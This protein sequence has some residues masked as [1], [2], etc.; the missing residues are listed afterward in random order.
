[1]G[2]LGEELLIVGITVRGNLLPEKCNRYTSVICEKIGMTLAHK[3]SLYQYPL[4]G[5]GGNGFTFF[6]PITESFITW[7]TWNDF[8]G[9]YLVIASCKSF[10]PQDVVTVL[11]ELGLEVAE[12]K[13]IKLRLD[14]QHVT[15]L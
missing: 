2:K 4:N 10:Y 11:Q 7:D 12:M 9:A 13:M 6:F 8:G 15:E 5:K 1:M 3:A 14:A